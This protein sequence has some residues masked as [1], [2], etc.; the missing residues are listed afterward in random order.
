MSHTHESAAPRDQAAL[1]RIL[2]R[3]AAVNP[4]PV[5]QARLIVLLGA[6]SGV[7]TTTLCY[8][9]A[10]AMGL[11]GHRVAAIDLNRDNRG[12]AEISGCPAA[13]S[14]DELLYGRGDLHEHLAP[15]VA[16]SLVLPTLED[17]YPAQWSSA[18]M[19]RFF[20]QLLGLGRHADILL[21]DAG[22]EPNAV[23][24]ELWAIAESL[25]LVLNPHV[26]AITAGYERI[27]T[28]SCQSR[29]QSIQVIMN[30]ASGQ[31]GHADLVAGIDA[32]ARKYLAL[33]IEHLGDVPLKSE[34]AAA[35][36]AAQPMVQRYSEH[37]ATMSLNKIA[38]SLVRQSDRGTVPELRRAA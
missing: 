27:R 26:D 20:D 5:R 9:L 21:I 31:A 23:T 8:N 13:A 2:A 6:A 29:R 36:R 12:L 22:S 35:G 14:V 32:T 34:I 24:D 1:L 28:L 17:A 4:A 16:A 3:R 25:V 38:E 37:S 33:P 10:C 11:A 18:G 19:E 7:G 30:R 15:G